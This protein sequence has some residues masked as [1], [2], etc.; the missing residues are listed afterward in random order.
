MSTKGTPSLLDS[1]RHARLP[2][3]KSLPSGLDGADNSLLKVG[4][5]LLHDDNGFLKRIFLVYLLVELT[6]DGK[7]G[8]IAVENELVSLEGRR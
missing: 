4:R 5:I 6:E 2:F 7:I 3:I 1:G 8:N